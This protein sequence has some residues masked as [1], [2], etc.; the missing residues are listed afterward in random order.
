MSRMPAPWGPRWSSW[1]LTFPA[2][3]VFLA[4]VVY[5]A[6]EGVLLSFFDANMLDLASQHDRSGRYF[7]SFVGWA[8]YEGLFADKSF[9]ESLRVMA[10][11]TLATTSLELAFALMVALLFEYVWRPPQWLKVLLLVPMFVIP[12]VAGLTFRYVFDPL[13]GAL[14]E[15]LRPFGL[16]APDL[17]GSPSGA[18][19]LIVWQDFWRMWPFVFLILAAGLK[20]I[21]KD[22]LEAYSLDGGSPQRAIGH[23]ILPVLMPSIFV[24]AGLKAIESLK[25]FTEIYTM[26]GGG[27]G[28]STTTLSLF[29]VREGFD[30]LKIPK[31]AAAG[32]LLLTV[33][34]LV[35]VV[36]SSWALWRSRLRR[37]GTLA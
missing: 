11:F 27:P 1:M 31:A 7:G 28:G 22:V 8:N 13:D 25:A 14:A 36:Y 5:P 17:L 19:A 21:P 35:G 33:G 4:L 20:T 18:F 9:F 3:V 32:T 30:S 37:S 34:V 12:L 26:T 16:E 24:A 10:A 23:I 15:V 2:G 29:I 6:L